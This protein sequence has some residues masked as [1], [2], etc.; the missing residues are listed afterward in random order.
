MEP[1]FNEF[2]AVIA[3]ICVYFVLFMKRNLFENEKKIETLQF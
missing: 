1:D 3:S 2:F